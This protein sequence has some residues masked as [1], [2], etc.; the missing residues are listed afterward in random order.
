MALSRS[1]D[2]S[3][4][5]RFAVLRRKW[6]TAGKYHRVVLIGS[7]IVLLGILGGFQLWRRSSGSNPPPALVPRDPRLTYT[8]PFRNIHPEV[9]FVGDAA[10]SEC[11]AEETRSY[12]EHPMGRSMTPVHELLSLLDSDGKAA[13]F[14]ASQSRFTVEQRGERIYHR[15]TRLDAEGQPI[16]TLESEVQFAIGS[17]THGYSFLSERQGYLFQTPISWYN[18]KRIWG[19]SP[20]F[21]AYQLPGR[22]IAPECLHCHAN[23]VHP[24]ENTFNGYEK[25]IFDGLAIGCERCHGP[26]AL[27]VQERSDA[28]AVKGAIDYTIFNPSK[29]KHQE[30]IKPALRDAVCE[31]C[32]LSG[33]ARVLPRGRKLYDFRPG[34]LLEPFWAIYVREQHG[35]DRDKAV[36]HVVQMH[37]SRCFRESK[38]NAKL[39][40]VSCHNPHEYVS[41]RDRVPYYRAR[42]LNCHESHGCALPREERLRA[43]KEDSC[44]DCHMPR[45]SAIDI[46]HTAAT[47][48][49]I[50]RRRAA[51]SETGIEDLRFDSVKAFSEPASRAD[52]KERDRDRGV[53]LMQMVS[54][55]KGD[56]Q[57]FALE[58][59]G[60]LSEWLEAHPDDVDAWLARGT[61]FKTIGRPDEA[62]FSYEKALE[63]APRLETALRSAAWF[64]KETGRSYKSLDYWRRV[65]EVNPAIP[66]YHGNLALLLA[67]TGAWEES[68]EQCQIWLKLDPG[69]VEGRRLLAQCLRQLGERQAANAETET[70]R[71]LEEKR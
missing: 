57:R 48:H 53:A 56:R 10:C 32:H 50:V 26:G 66:E 9:D 1:S 46:P 29:R 60:L 36:N 2:S 47:D 71:R 43:N 34:L 3:E 67:Q 51:A 65:L 13:S 18:Q 11:H 64:S 37:L 12:R 21:A 5:S 40:C 25:P 55:G 16:Y 17:G 39:E 14:T 61:A 49:R 62:L 6:R 8:G 54:D 41:H 44:I 20:G 31:Q 63:Y 33:E 52:E 28:V 30:R 7:L 23:L 38:A 69:S 45:Y 42:C 35:E 68:R 70:L 15:Q 58:A 4:S 22:A 59:V 27:H 19:L 24:R